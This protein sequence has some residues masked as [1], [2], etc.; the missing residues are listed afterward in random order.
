MSKIC[1]ENWGSRKFQACSR[2]VFQLARRRN[3]NFGKLRVSPQHLHAAVESGS[4]AIVFDIQGMLATVRRHA[5][6]IHS[7]HL[8]TNYCSAQIAECRSTSSA[9]LLTYL[10]LLTLKPI[11]VAFEA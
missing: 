8:P 7:M 10:S 2:C 5:S 1:S 9:L 4:R 3:S 11:C 6:V